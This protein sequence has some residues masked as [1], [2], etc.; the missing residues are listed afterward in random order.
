[1]SAVFLLYSTASSTCAKSSY[2]LLRGWL[3]L[4]FYFRY[5]DAGCGSY[6]HCRRPCWRSRPINSVLG[7]WSQTKTLAS[8][9]A[10]ALATN[11]FDGWKAT[12]KIL[13]SNFL[14]WAVISCTQVRVSRF[15]SRMLQSWPGKKER[16][17]GNEWTN[18]LTLFAE[19]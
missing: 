16:D 17:G 11:G 13:S 5:E 3:H 7:L 6:A 19:Q 9:S 12:S 1:V 15:H 18:Q 4:S 2:S 14:R 10:P 8:A